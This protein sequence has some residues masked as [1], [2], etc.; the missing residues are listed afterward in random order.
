M[1]TYKVVP[2][3]DD[4]QARKIILKGEEPSLQAT[5]DKVGDEAPK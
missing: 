2:V 4:I 5:Y 1:A 3:V